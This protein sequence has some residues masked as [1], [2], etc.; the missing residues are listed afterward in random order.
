MGLTV[1]P[2]LL[3]LTVMLQGDPRTWPVLARANLEAAKG[4]H[5]AFAIT[6]TENTSTANLSYDA[7]APMRQR[8]ELRTSG[9]RYEFLQAPHGGAYVD[10]VSKDYEEFQPVPYF[11]PPPP[12]TPLE[13]CL[14]PPLFSPARI[15]RESAN[16][17]VV[18]ASDPADLKLDFK[19]PT[20][21]LITF[22]VTVDSK[23][24]MT[25]IEQSEETERGVNRIIWVR[26][27]ADFTLTTQGLIEDEVPEGYVPSVF[28][29]ALGTLSPGSMW[30]SHLVQGKSGPVSLRKEG[31]KAVILVTAPDCEVTARL[32]PVLPELTAEVQKLGATFA[33]LSLS[34]TPGNATAYD[35]TGDMARELRVPMTPYFFVLDGSGRIV[36]GFAG[37]HTDQKQNLF[38]VLTKALKG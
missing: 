27:A 13:S 20:G 37:Y 19:T 28:A 21:E 7:A 18:K 24:N 31:T 26:T 34:S 33:E 25:R 32:R 30:P 1:T 35:S 6:G 3:A 16:W 11:L 8:I 5:L 22:S 36:R 9:G 2:T 23:G 17:K 38:D 15:F 10:H 29:R 14:P 4:V 12:E